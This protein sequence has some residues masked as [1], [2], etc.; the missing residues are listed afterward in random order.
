M[1]CIQQ[2]EAFMHRTVV[3][4]S[5]AVGVGL[6]LKPSAPVPGGSARSVDVQRLKSHF[7]SVDIELKSRDVATLLPS[8]RARRAEL[9]SWLRDYRNAGQFPVNDKF[10]S[11][12]P[13]FRDSKGTLCAMAYLIDR[14]GRKDIV[15]KVEATRN[16]AY[17]AELADDPALIAW[18]DSS[19]LSVAEAARIQ[20]AY[21]GFPDEPIRIQRVDG[22]FALA[23]MGLAGASLATS[24]INIVKPSSASGLLGI[25]AGALSI[26]VGAAN[27]NVNRGTDRVAAATMGVGALSLGAG[28]YGLLDARRGGD[29]DDWDRDR[30]RGRGRNRV[31]MSILPDVVMEKSDPRVGMRFSGR[32]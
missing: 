12:T 1:P 10:E 20:P 7:D 9:T 17:I 29:D 13:F 16:T 28:I 21:G 19:G 11:P 32:F 31:S 30:R 8:Q 15:D 23:A 26:G 24:A 18:L 4:V 5:L 3:I 25:V 14:S 22:D 27:V 6:S 2:K